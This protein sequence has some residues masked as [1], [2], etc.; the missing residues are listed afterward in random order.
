MMKILF[1]SF[2]FFFG[3]IACIYGKYKKA[4]IHTGPRPM[5]TCSDPSGQEDS[6]AYVPCN[7]DTSSKAGSLDHGTAF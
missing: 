2:S 7:V 5:G 4:Y 6:M 3:T 1:F